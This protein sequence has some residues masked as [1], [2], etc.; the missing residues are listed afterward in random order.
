MNLLAATFLTLA[1]VVL[2]ANP[3]YGTGE[4]RAEPAVPASAGPVSAVGG[5]FVPPVGGAHSSARVARPFDPPASAWSAGHRGVDLAA[6][7]GAGVGSPGPGTVTFAG[8]VAGRGVVVVAHAGGLRSS[9]EPVAA[10]VAVGTSVAAGDPLG[11]VEAT[12]S[13]HCAPE[14]CVHWG[15]RSGGRYV[16]PLA[17]LRPERPAVVLLPDS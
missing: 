12:S 4:A 16:D 2:P 15:V 9:L 1:L 14:S 8:T 11:T 3:A 5:G 17:L 6:T 10:T 7:V 13:G